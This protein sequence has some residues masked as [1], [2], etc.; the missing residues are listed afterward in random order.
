M[1]DIVSFPPASG[2][3]NM[4]VRS[5]HMGFPAP[6]HIWY[7][8]NAHYSDVIMGAMQSQIINLTIVDS[9]I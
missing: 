9:T 6:E 4:S 5:L 3:T 8:Q 7:E 1:Y 2:N